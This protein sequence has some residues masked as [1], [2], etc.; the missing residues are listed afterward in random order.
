MIA[1]YSP[2]HHRGEARR[3]YRIC[4]VYRARYRNSRVY[5]YLTRVT[6]SINI[7]FGRVPTRLLHG[8][9]IHVRSLHDLAFF[10]LFIFGAENFFR[11]RIS[12]QKMRIERSWDNRFVPNN[13]TLFPVVVPNKKHR[14][15]KCTDCSIVNMNILTRINK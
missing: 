1:L 9:A 15:K 14:C 5:M 10:S 3:A 6:S 8:N 4:D 2:H 12:F 13:V 11:L 7:E